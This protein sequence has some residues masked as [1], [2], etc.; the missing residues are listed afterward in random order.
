MVPLTCP[1]CR[2]ANPTGA[3]FCYFDGHLLRP[4]GGTTVDP[5]LLPHEFV[6]G[7]GRRCGTWDD[8]VG[9]CRDEWEEAR[10]LLKTGAFAS[11]LDAV[12]RSDLGRSAREAQATPD[13]DAALHEFIEC[14]PG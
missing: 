1:R 11:Y 4:G 5:R 7:S 12:G 13:A 10:E 3:S 6:F 14:L 9:A 8:L 2:R